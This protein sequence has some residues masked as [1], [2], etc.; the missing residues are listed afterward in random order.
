MK[1]ASV[2]YS[3]PV[4]A[5]LLA[6]PD[7]IPSHPAVGGTVAW[8]SVPFSPRLEFSKDNVEKVIGLQWQNR[9]GFTPEFPGSC[10]VFYRAKIFN[11]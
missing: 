6:L 1:S 9:S 4:Q 10:I 7:L 5:G 3:T 2:Y 11:V 8:I